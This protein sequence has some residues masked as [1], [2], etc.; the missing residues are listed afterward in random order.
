ML[1]EPAGPE[2]AAMEKRP[3]AT[4][5]AGAPSWS[6]PSEAGAA[7]VRAKRADDPEGLVGEVERKREKG[8]NSGRS[9]ACSEASQH[10][11]AERDGDFCDRACEVHRRSPFGLGDDRDGPRFVPSSFENYAKSHLFRSVGENSFSGG[12][13]DAGS[14]EVGR[15]AG[16]NAHRVSG[17]PRWPSSVP[18][19]K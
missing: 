1:I 19:R 6:G 8:V 3:L 7:E 4:A 13:R 5:P 12:R 9:G 18:E 17:P 10:V 11:R 15:D 16:S 14:T 2:R